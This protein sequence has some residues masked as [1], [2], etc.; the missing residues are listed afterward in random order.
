MR[1]S[2][3]LRQRVVKFVQS[4]VSK[5]EAAR[6]F[7]VGEANV[8]RWLRPGGMA[9]KRPGPRRTHKLDWDALRRHVEA[10]PDRTQAE[11]ARQLPVSRPCIWY[12]LQRL[13]ITH[14]KKDR[15]PRT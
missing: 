15:V 3:D 4:G 14:Q 1:C 13:Q 9:Y 10:H 7:Q 12:A 11:R 8:Y 5:A 6:R 2:S